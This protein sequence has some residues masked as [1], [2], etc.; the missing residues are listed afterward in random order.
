VRLVIQAGAI[1]R[2]GEALVLDMGEPVCIL[3]VAERLIRQENASI[4][5]EFTGLRPGEKLEEVLLAEAE[6]DRRPAH[7]LITQVPVPPIAPARL[8][9][10]DVDASDV[11]IIDRLRSLA[12]SPPARLPA[13][14]GRPDLSGGR[15]LTSAVTIRDPA[16][17]G[18]APSKG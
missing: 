14:P 18:G 10:L 8:A 17:D 12:A 7:P 4:A 6:D 2:S 16:P 3:D 1:G 11:V 9:D 15:A 5:V 13:P